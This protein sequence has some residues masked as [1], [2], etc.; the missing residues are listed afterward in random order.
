MPFAIT[1][2]SDIQRQLLLPAFSLW[3]LSQNMSKYSARIQDVKYPLDLKYT[4]KRIPHNHP[5]IIP[6]CPIEDKTFTASL[7]TNHSTAHPTFLHDWNGLQ[8]PYTTPESS[9]VTVFASPDP[10]HAPTRTLSPPR[11]PCH[12]AIREHQR[13]CVEFRMVER[14]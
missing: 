3:G 8:T 5:F 6:P 12:D 13:S 9:Q 1:V 4:T 10:L 2:P 11:L 7:F 14:K